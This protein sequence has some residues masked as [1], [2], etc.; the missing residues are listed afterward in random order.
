VRDERQLVKHAADRKETGDLGRTPCEA[1]PIPVLRRQD[2][3]EKYLQTAGIHERHAV[4]IDD[5]LGHVLGLGSGDL[6]VQDRGRGE[7][8]LSANVKDD[9]AALARDIDV[10]SAFHDWA[11]WHRF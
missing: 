8:D 1:D 4:E 6:L 3:R 7:I 11:P 9:R 5:D 2:V 10:Q